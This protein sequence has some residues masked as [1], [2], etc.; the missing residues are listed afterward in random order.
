MAGP[1]GAPS[2]LG[3][4]ARGRFFGCA[5]NAALGSAQT[6]GD[7]DAE[8]WTTLLARLQTTKD[9]TSSRLSF[10]QLQTLL[11]RVSG[12]MLEITGAQI[13]LLDRL[14]DGT[15]AAAPEHDEVLGDAK[16][17]LHVLTL[18]PLGETLAT[19][20]EIDDTQ[21]ERVI[22]RADVLASGGSLSSTMLRKRQG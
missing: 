4:A 12:A 16:S 17:L 15:L 18:P 6:T 10:A 11:Q 9:L 21:Y 14:L 1:T 2:R 19:Q 22:E 13:N 20:T 3:D 5:L 7:E 8:R